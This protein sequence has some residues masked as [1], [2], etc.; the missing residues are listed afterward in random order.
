MKKKKPYLKTVSEDTVTII[1]KD[2]GDILDEYR[3]TRKVVVNSRE[4]FYM[5]YAQAQ[6]MFMGL[7]SAEMKI[8][9]W[10]MLNQANYD[11]KVYLV[12]DTKKRIQEDMKIGAESVKRGIINLVK[13]EVLIHQ[14]KKRSST[15]MLN[16]LYVWKGSQTNRVK[17]LEYTLSLRYER[18]DSI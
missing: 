7:T 12:L 10:L 14:G 1:D 18:D 17:A 15:Y 13:K 8:V 9:V 6:N 4:A 5:T 3:K 16:P 11:N 2:N